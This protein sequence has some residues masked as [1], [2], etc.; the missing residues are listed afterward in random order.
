MFGGITA[1]CSC[2][3][4]TRLLKQLRN[5]SVAGY[6]KARTLFSSM[7]IVYMFI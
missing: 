6:C 5:N 2:L 7:L 4:Q 3:T 1:L